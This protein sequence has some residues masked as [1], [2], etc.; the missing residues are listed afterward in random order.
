MSGGRKGGFVEPVTATGMGVDVNQTGSE[1]VA[2]DVDDLG[3]CGD[4]GL[5]HL[6]IIHDDTVFDQKIGIGDEMITHDQ[7]GMGKS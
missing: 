4:V 2:T 5:T 7:L 3:I 6:A 1:I